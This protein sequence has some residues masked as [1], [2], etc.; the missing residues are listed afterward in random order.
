[1]AD[2]LSHKIFHKG[3]DDMYKNFKD[4]FVIVSLFLLTGMV[5]AQL[6]GC[7]GGG[8][9]GAVL[10]TDST[11]LQVSLTD[12]KSD[13]YA[14][15]FIAIKEI[16]VVPVGMEGAADHN[17]GLPVIKT[18]AE[19]LSVD[20]LTL[21]FQQEILGTASLPPGNY[22]QVRLILAPNLAGG[23]PVN[24]LTLKS[25]PAVKIPLT[26]PSANQS[27][28]KVLGKFTVKSGILNAILLDFDPNTAIVERGNGDYNLKPT[29]I[30]IVQLS[31]PLYDNF[32]VLSG[33][34]KSTFKDFSSATVSVYPEGSSSPIASGSVFSNLS[35]SHWEAP[36]TSF[37]P[38]GSY[39]VHVEAKGFKLYTSGMQ[40]VTGGNETPVGILELIQGP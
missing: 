20:I 38:S 31:S 26:T 7:S 15:V 37:V 25:D 36:F 30:R 23:D 34:V 13:D 17:P 28:L 22:N 1:M 11:R 32:G 9:S 19:P 24:Y 5:A 27:G 29:G 18:F 40:E 21:R 16:R 39:R 33:T 3:G 8:S 12:K 6:P 35:S 10:S 2:R 4:F 14:N